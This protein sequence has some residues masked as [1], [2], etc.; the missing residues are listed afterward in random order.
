M[1]P[2]ALFL[3]HSDY[4]ALVAKGVAQKIRERDEDGFF[5]RVVTVHPVA[6][7][8]RTIVLDATHVIHEFALG[9]LL[10][11]AS[12]WAPL[13]LA[14]ATLRV[15]I[16]VAFIAKKNGVSVI[17]ATD[18]FLVGI[19]GWALSRLLR[20]PLAVSIHADYAKRF[21]LDVRS[22]AAAR[23]RTLSSWVPSFVLR[24]ADLVLP[25]R[26]SLAAWAESCGADPERVRVIPHGVDVRD[27]APTSS[28]LLQRWG[29]GLDQ[30][31]ISFVG[32]VHAE[33]Y[34]NDLS[35]V[36]TELAKRRNDFVFVF[37]GDGPMRE[38]LEADLA[39]GDARAR[40]RFPGSIPQEEALALRD[41][42][43][44]SVALMGGF[45]LLE[46]CASGSPVIAYDVEWHAEVVETGN[47]GFLLPEGDVAGVVR[48]IETL[49]NDAEL[50]ARMGR[51]ARA[52]VA[53]HYST[54]RASKAK[55]E[56]YRE[57]L[58]R[59]RR[60]SRRTNS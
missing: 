53:E 45:S 2:V 33:N 37:A 26:A 57:L 55:L 30:K 4:D 27:R 39:G 43:T 10:T 49:L 47:T 41:A 52:R 60:R 50:A 36:A 23:W 44:I 11:R 22:G 25:I 32:R 38:K 48:A 13:P 16:S 34:A 3:V 28:Q 1:R 5:E 9:R 7:Q 15:V 8:R 24:R 12:W 35:L 31:V 51:A 19:L 42:S 29:I 40:V 59:H 56:C 58:D 21:S 18:P 14:I 46:A 17:R 54:E 20:V 6:F